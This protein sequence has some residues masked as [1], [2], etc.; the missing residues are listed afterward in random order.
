M[1]ALY[2]NIFNITGNTCLELFTPRQY[3]L[4]DIL[5]KTS[6]LQM[7]PLTT[8]HFKN[9]FKIIVSFSASLCVPSLEKC[10]CHYDKAL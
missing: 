8:E 2:N 3:R 9:Y 7:T 6:A 4:Q 5:I 1:C 10:V